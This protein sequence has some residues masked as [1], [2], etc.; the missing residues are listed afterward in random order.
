[1]ILLHSLG[2][3]TE[4][5]H[6]LIYTDWTSLFH[7]EANRWAD[8]VQK[9]TENMLGAHSKEMEKKIAASEF[10][11]Y[12]FFFLFISFLLLFFH[13]IYCFDSILQCLD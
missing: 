2:K 3:K 9:S 12:Y 13:N 10:V 7:Q 6:N 8:Q 1:M 11:F 5:E 4:D